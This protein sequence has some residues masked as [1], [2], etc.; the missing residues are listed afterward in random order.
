MNCLSW[1][2]VLGLVLSGCAAEDKAS[3]N[4]EVELLNELASQC[5]GFGG[6]LE[7][8]LDYKDTFMVP[9]DTVSEGDAQ[10]ADV[11][12]PP[13]CGRDEGQ[14][15]CPKGLG[16]KYD[17]QTG[18]L[19][20]TW[21]D[22]FY[23]GAELYSQLSLEDET[24]TLTLRDHLTEGG[25]GTA[26]I[27]FFD[28]QAEFKPQSAGPLKLTLLHPEDETFNFLCTRNLTL[29]LGDGQGFIERDDMCA[30]LD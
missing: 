15:D 19:T 7:A 4:N 6:S 24:Y 17:D 3:N 2:A 18:V 29:H 11:T 21:S 20:L 8:A 28:Y 16:W 14:I 27:C 26:C 23:C 13:A 5:G 1:L 9:T 22:Y 10:E 30:I 12:E 25:M